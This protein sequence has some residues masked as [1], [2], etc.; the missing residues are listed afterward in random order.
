MVEIQNIDMTFSSNIH[1]INMGLWFYDYEY[2]LK[3]I[4]YSDDF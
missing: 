2:F 4:E 1:N 3:L